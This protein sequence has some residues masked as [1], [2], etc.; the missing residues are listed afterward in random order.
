[1]TTQ[2]AYAAPNDDVRPV[3]PLVLTAA[4]LASWAMALFNLFVSAM[5]EAGPDSCGEVSCHGDGKLA[6]VFLAAAGLGPLLTMAAWF[7]MRPSRAMIRYTLV[8]AALVVP[9]L[10]DALLVPLV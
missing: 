4:M 9:L 6:L 2:P 5:T 8:T 7:F 1:M 10:V 3:T